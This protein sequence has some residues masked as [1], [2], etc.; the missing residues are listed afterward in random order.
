[1][2]F[3]SLEFLTLF[4]PL[5]LI[6]YALSPSRWRNLTLLVFSWAFYG[7]WDPS[8]LWVLVGVTSV[9][10][11]SGLLL[12]HVS[13]QSGRRLV[14]A[15]AATSMVGLLAFYKYGNLVVELL[16]G[17]VVAATA[18]GPGV[19]AMAHLAHPAVGRC[20]R[21]VAPLVAPRNSLGPANKKP[22][23]GQRPAR[24]LFAR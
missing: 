3:A 5:F 23:Q 20:R 13:S 9:A 22:R 21:A 15:L 10:F 6:A 24:F 19:R 12:G 4:F 18:G 1:M 14:M 2:V 11:A 17:P 8:F 7:W 16:V